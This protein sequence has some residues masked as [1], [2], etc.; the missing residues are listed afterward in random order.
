MTKEDKLLLTRYLSA[1]LPYEVIVKTILYNGRLIGVD[2]EKGNLHLRDINDGDRYYSALNDDP[3]PYL[4]SMENM[5]KE[6]RDEY[7]IITDSLYD[8]GISFLKI[9]YL[10]I[11]W[12]ILVLY[13]KD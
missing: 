12:I 8:T 7:N 6:E 5:T 4:R 10:N 2:V 9:G 3:K 11:I 1:A 13:R